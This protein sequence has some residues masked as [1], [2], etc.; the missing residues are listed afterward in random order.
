MQTITVQAA[1]GTK[2]PR[3]G[4]RGRFITDEKP[5]S[6]PST[7]YYRRRIRSGELVTVGQPTPKAAEE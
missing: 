1:P 2:V 5:V 4:V 6:V 3:E 7:P